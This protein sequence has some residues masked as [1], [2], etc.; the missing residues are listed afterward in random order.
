MSRVLKH[1]LGQLGVTAIATATV[2]SL[3]ACGNQTES[4]KHASEQRSDVS[5]NDSRQS[6]TAPPLP[7]RSVNN[8]PFGIGIGQSITDL[9]E[10]TKLD[11][12]GLYKIESP[13]KPHSAFETV[14]VVAYPETGVC[15]IRGIGR[16]IDNDGA[17]VATRGAVDELADA[18]RT[19]YGSARK[20][21]TC[22][23]SGSCNPEYWMMYMS[24][25]ER[26]YGY[27]FKEKSTVF[28]SL[29]LREV[30]VAA[31]VSDTQTGYAIV[32]YQGTNKESCDAAAKRGSA[33][34]L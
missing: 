4:S 7:A 24:N 26:Y 28:Q 9:G 32:E 13:P 21:D 2:A 16:N 33:E 14:V 20:I 30:D 23:G 22:F 15:V 11:A 6:V 5:V 8:G 19:K 27:E 3:S 34:S 18:L 29:K 31:R 12:P 17:G 1:G 10:T 25:N